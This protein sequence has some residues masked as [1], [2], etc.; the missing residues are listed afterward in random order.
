MSTVS[1]W[2]ATSVAVL[3]L[4]LSASACEYNGASSLPLPGAVGT[5]GYRISMTFTDATNLVVKETCRAN[6]V[7][8]GSVESIELDDDLNAV[9]VCRIKKDVSLPANVRATMRET[10]LLGERYVA[11]DPP[12]SEE[13]QGELAPDTAVAV[14]D[15]H[16]VP[17]VEVVFGALSQVLNGGGLASIETISRELATAF[18]GADLTGTLG[19]VRHLVGTL[20][21]HRDEVVG[22]LES[23]NRLA[24]QL[25]RQRSVIGE[26]L[27]VVPDGLAALERQ[28]PRLMETVRAL[29][30][31][32]GVA[33]PLI[34][35]SQATTVANLRDLAPILRDLAKEK[36]LLTDA[37]EGIITFP[38]P[39]NSLA[40]AQGDY[41]GMFATFSLDIDTLNHLLEDLASSGASLPTG[42][43]ATAPDGPSGPQLPG[44]PG[45]PALPGLPGLPGDLLGGLDG[46]LGD[47]GAAS[48]SSSGTDSLLPDLGSL[49]QV[50]SR[51]TGARE[52]SPDLASLLTGEGR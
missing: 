3:A 12:P 4:A 36:R 35:R 40:T 28:R 52:A 25:S 16:V 17:D 10:S 9:V 34:R 30:R 23:L 41:A 11:L 45:L 33:L 37:I 2:G 47:G 38:F 20:D 8:I 50:P 26:A 21:D 46:L 13:P 27:D 6:D 7:V 42:A 51:R 24:G 39:T 48:S 1:R 22:A 15:T 32:S 18:E 44:L 19:Q 43:P 5:D 29:S 31:L 14:S 49:G